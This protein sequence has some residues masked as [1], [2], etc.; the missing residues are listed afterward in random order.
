MW[1]LGHVGGSSRYG[2]LGFVW[3]FFGR[4]CGRSKGT[5]GLGGVGILRM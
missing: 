5:V 2:D 1:D 4:G 3:Y